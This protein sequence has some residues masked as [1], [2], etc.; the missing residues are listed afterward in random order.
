MTPSYGCATLREIRE[1]PAA[2]LRYLIIF[3]DGGAL[4]VS[5][6]GRAAGWI[7][8]DFDPWVLGCRVEWHD[9]SSA[10][11]VT[12]LAVCLAVDAALEDRGATCEHDLHR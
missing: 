8:D 3:T 11:R 10:V 2:L 12:A 9:L 5:G 6:D 1:S 4:A 7:V